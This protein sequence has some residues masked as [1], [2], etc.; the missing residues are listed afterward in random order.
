MIAGVLLGSGCGR[1]AAPDPPP[2]PL[3][4]AHAHNDY[5]H[6]RPLLDALD[7]GFCSVEADVHLVDGRLLVAHSRAFTRPE[8]TLETLYL[9]PLRARV[10]AHGGRV[11]RQGPE[12]FL[13]IDFKTPAAPTWEALR[14]VLSVYGDI[15]TTFRTHRI[16]TNAVTIILS[17]NAPRAQL[18]AEPVRH[19]AVDGRLPDLEGTASAGSIPWVSASWSEVFTWRGRDAFPPAEAQRLRELVARAHAQG[20]KIRFWGGPDTPALWKEQHA[21]GVDL[22]NTDRLA[23]LRKFLS[24]HR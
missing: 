24:V 20:R 8:R 15:L 5:A 14:G 11:Y 21:A 2:V 23:E 4:Q 16:E 22:I 7:Q 10:R 1:T 18:A 17:G 12:F 13:L 3:P 9:D 6:A 19:A